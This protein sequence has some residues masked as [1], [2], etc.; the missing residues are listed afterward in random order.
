MIYMSLRVHVPVLR[1]QVHIPPRITF[2]CQKG[3]GC[4]QELMR[5]SWHPIARACVVELLSRDGVIMKVALRTVPLRGQNETGSLNSR[6]FVSR[7]RIE[8]CLPDR[9]CQVW[10]FLTVAVFSFLLLIAILCFFSGPSEINNPET[11]LA[12]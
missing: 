12:R 6:M 5:R 3:P 10:R 8:R 4:L 11:T 9:H 7:K 1:R 2:T